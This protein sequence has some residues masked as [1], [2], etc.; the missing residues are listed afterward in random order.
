M[1]FDR[2]TIQK[3]LFVGTVLILVYLGLQH[4]SIVFQFLAWLLYV[5]MPFIVAICCSFFLNVPLKAIEKHLFRPRN[6][7][8]VNP[9]LE[10]MRRPVALTLS[11]L[12]FVAVIVAFLIIIIP[13]IGKSLNSLILA[14][15]DAANNLNN[16][17][18]DWA[19]NNDYVLQV[20]KY[21]N[22]EYGKDIIE[23]GKKI[24]VNT[25]VINSDAITGALS[26]FL[27]SNAG[28]LVNYTMNM[29]SSIF[30]AAVNVFLGIVLS[31]YALLK[32][33]KIASDVKKLIYA[34]CPPR[35]SDFIVEVGVLTNKSFYNTITGQMM[36]CIILG[37]LTALGMTILGFPYAAL[38]GVMVAILSWVPMFGVYIGAGIGALFLLTSDPMQ[39]VWFIV[40][41]IIL[42]QIEG[43][44]IYPRVVGNNVGLPAIIVISAIV[45]FSNFFGIIGLLVCVPITSVLYTLVRRLV[46][47]RLR[48]RRVPH[49]KYEVKEFNVRVRPKVH[50][51]KHNTGKR[52][53]FNLP[54]K[55]IIKEK[56]HKKQTEHKNV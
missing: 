18:K 10:K 29:L 35:T 9:I 15:P 40:F 38:V 44:L 53:K 54:M 36:E 56:A 52:V 13:E 8:P 27:S 47:M 30:N 37:S 6:G 33:E 22:P 1:N 34:I 2:K 43:N 39:A 12:I 17:I 46:F 41:M 49:E 4:M 25:T 50:K 42:Q 23:N 3:I 55:F 28:G 24:G 48:S 11:I 31:I 16:Q 21:F 14:I 26:G 51:A 5:A 7:N 19:D 20:V 32:K 45:L